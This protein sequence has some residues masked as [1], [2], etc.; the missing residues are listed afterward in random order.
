MR[1]SGRTSP[2]EADLS[3]TEKERKPFIRKV[4]S[5]NLM[6]TYILVNHLAIGASV[7]KKFRVKSVE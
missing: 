5:H 3:M 1:E 2:P 6:K 7:E 4:E